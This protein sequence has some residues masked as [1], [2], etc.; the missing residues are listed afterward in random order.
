VT[1]GQVLDTDAGRVWTLTR[2]EGAPDLGTTAV[3]AG[4]TL[5]AFG[6]VAYGSHDLSGEV[7]HRAWLYTP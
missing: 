3:W 5:V 1:Y 4:N 7:T 6:G 2:P